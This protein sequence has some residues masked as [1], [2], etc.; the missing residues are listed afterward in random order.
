M[1]LQ[2]RSIIRVPVQS[3][4]DDGTIR[5]IFKLQLQLQNKVLYFVVLTCIDTKEVILQR[6]AMLCEQNQSV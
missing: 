1:F 2:R 6:F 3:K 4:D 5:Q